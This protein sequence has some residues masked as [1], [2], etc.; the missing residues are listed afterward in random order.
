MLSK[1][2]L[3][4]KRLNEIFGQ[5]LEFSKVANTVLLKKF[6]ALNLA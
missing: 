1:Q 6:Y 4:N 5:V 2:I 3:F